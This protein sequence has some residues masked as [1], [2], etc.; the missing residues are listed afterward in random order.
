MLRRS[1]LI[2][3]EQVVPF[4]GLPRRWLRVPAMALAWCAQRRL[5]Q[6]LASGADPVAK[7][8]RAC[9][10]RRL[11]AMPTRR[12]LARAIERLPTEAQDPW[13][14]ARVSVPLHRRTILAAQ[15]AL[16]DLANA[17]VSPGPVGAQGVAL[18]RLL[19]SDGG[20]PLFGDDLSMLTDAVVQA[21]EELEDD[22]CY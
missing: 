2:C 22:R 21:M 3:G 5:D 14:A 11:T 4:G 8:L 7:P 20:S 6:E 17:L 1:D 15:P 13:R 16:Q 12:H 19:L 9:E 10:A 18:A